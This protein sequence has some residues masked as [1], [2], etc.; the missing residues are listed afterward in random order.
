MQE[1][2]EKSGENGAIMRSVRPPTLDKADAKWYNKSKS[3][4]KGSV[5]L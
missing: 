3:T 5:V 1:F 2:S 4:P